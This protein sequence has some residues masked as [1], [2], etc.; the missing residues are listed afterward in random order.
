MSP[1]RPGDAL[2][3]RESDYPKEL[4]RVLG[5]MLGIAIV[6]GGTIGVGILRTPGIVAASLGHPALIIGAW[7]AGGLLAAMGASCFAELATMLPKAG[8]PYVY[9]RRAFGDFAGFGVGWA[10]WTVSVCGL[11]ALSVP[12]GEYAAQLVPPLAGFEHVIAVG[13]IVVLTA[14]N[15]FGLEVSGGAQQLLSLAKVVGLLVIVVGCF[16]FPNSTASAGSR[17][18]SLAAP[19]VVAFVPL[20]YS[21]Q[22]ISE[23]YAGWNSSIYLS[24]ED[25]DAARNVPRALFWG[26][27]AV[28][29]TYLAINAGLLVALPFETLASSPLPVAD[30][31]RMI[32]GG[33]SDR[34]VTVLAIVSLL[35]L[36]NVIVMFTPRIIFAL[37]RDGLVPA[38]AGRLNRAAVPGV[39][40]LMSAVPGSLLASGGSFEMLYSITAFLG[41]AV[42]AAVYLAYFSLRRRHPDLHRPYRAF[43]HPWI[44]GLVTAIS[45]GLLFGFVVANP[46]PSLYAVVILAANY[47]VYAWLRRHS[48]PSQ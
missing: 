1:G 23:T 33:A 31:A 7:V 22:I 13:V 34:V 26:V 6:V 41:V 44:P 32:F 8:G 38:P 10:D 25:H 48:D 4:R 16:L 3:A 5:V 15:W 46:R 2:A 21:M 28:T 9:A 18:H 37:S 47:P 27:L 43:G 17:A 45:I 14:V 20:L 35:G 12:V 11:A 30:A 40:M 19:I 24:E 39:A 29:V 36:L 42:N